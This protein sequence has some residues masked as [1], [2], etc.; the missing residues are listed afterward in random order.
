MRLIDRLAWCCTDVRQAGSVEQSVRGLLAQ[1]IFG[2]TLGY[3]DINND[4]MRTDLVFV[5]SGGEAR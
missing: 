4:Q 3:E 1:R 2:L 5:G